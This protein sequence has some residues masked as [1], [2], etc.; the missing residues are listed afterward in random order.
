VRACFL[1]W[2]LYVYEDCWTL[3]NDLIWACDILLTLAE[4]W[5]GIVGMNNWTASMKWWKIAD[6]MHHDCGLLVLFDYEF[7]Y[8]GLCLKESKSIFR[9]I[10]SKKWTVSLVALIIWVPKISCKRF[11]SFY[12]Y[13]MKIMT[14]VLARTFLFCSIGQERKILQFSLVYSC[15]AMHDLVFVV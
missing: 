2:H 9:V 4:H 7:S 10:L 13:R 1:W 15:I 11:S 8:A 5:T 3:F 12:A 14:W 6:G